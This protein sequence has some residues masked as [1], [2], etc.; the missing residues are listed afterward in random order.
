MLAA[1]GA[2]NSLLYYWWKP[3]F[4]WQMA[5]LSKLTGRKV[6][7]DPEA[8][9]TPSGDHVVEHLAC[10]GDKQSLLVFWFDAEIRREGISTDRWVSIGPRNITCVIRAI[11]AD[12]NNP[13][14]LYA[15]AEFGGV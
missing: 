5:D 9:T 12:P 3:A 8:W 7:T 4:D 2:G 6:Y 11:A 13:A 14:I 15:G 1:R 10:E